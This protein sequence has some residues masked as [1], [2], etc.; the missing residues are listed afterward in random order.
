[1]RSRSLTPCRFASR[2]CALL[3]CPRGARSRQVRVPG[4]AAGRDGQRGRGSGR[5]SAASKGVLLFA[6][7]HRAM[8]RPSKPLAPFLAKNPPVLR[9][10]SSGRKMSAAGIPARTGIWKAGGFGVFDPGI[11]ALSIATH[12]LPPLLRDRGGCSILRRTRDAPVAAQIKFDGW[13]SCRLT[14]D[15]DWL[16]TGPQTLGHR[17]GTNAGRMVLS[18]GGAEARRSA[19]S[20]CMKSLEAEY[21]TPLR[22]LR[23]DHR[24]RYLRRGHRTAAARR[25]RLHARPAPGRRA[26]FRPNQNTSGSAPP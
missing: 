26:V 15:L 2:R 16:Q 12:I 9:P 17:R 18:L 19:A 21:P 23:R 7:W 20:R 5:R 6:S 22:A 1:M 10:R 14:M 25:R 3:R 11:N 24:R 13:A 4:K 8:R